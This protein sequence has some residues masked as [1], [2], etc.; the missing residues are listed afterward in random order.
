MSGLVL[1]LFPGIGM[2][3]HAFELEG[4]CVVRGPDLVWGGDVKK[5]RPEVGYFH[6]V[7]G[8]P[9]CQAF[10][11]IG[12]VNRARYGVQS[13]MPDLIPEFRRL[14]MRIAPDWWVMEN[15]SR[16]YAP[17]EGCY[18]LQIDN[19][20]LGEQQKRVRTF[21][22]DLPLKVRKTAKRHPNP[23]HTVTTKGG[24]DWKGSR[25]KRGAYSL[26]DACE[27]QGLPRDF[28]SHTPFKRVEAM[29]L[30]ANGVP[31]PMGRAIAKAVKRALKHAMESV[32]FEV[33]M[34]TDGK[35]GK[36]WRACK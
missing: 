5:F 12:N 17:F 28:M 10:S 27:L 16:A 20:E 15:S 2:L 3:D 24:V 35:S 32:T 7:I 4:F 19:L 30:V 6:G 21:W 11:P 13:V 34:I 33:P 25:A 8:G 22:S 26:E 14:V 9:P 1:S 29:R 31:I 36:T 23:K 18:E